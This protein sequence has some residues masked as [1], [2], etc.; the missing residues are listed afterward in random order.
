MVASGSVYGREREL[1][2]LGNALSE[3]RSDRGTLVLLTGEPGI[4]KTRLAS[5][6]AERA[7]AGG[8]RV[9]WGRAWEAGGAP[10]YWPWIAVV[11]GDSVR[12]GLNAFLRQPRASS[13]RPRPG[14]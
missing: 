11:N 2:E 8:A 14:R 6:F 9:S 13:R 12:L 1:T 3:A 10:A 4:G 7:E 5:A